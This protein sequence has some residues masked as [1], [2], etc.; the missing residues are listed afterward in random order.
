MLEQANDGRFL[1]GFLRSPAEYAPVL[2]HVWG[3]EFL[4]NAAGVV[5][6]VGL[7]CNNAYFRERSSRDDMQFFRMAAMFDVVLSR[8]PLWRVYFDVFESGMFAAGLYNREWDQW[9]PSAS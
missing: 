9:E 2:A 4:R 5:L 6:G 3:V 8:E 7:G 1:C